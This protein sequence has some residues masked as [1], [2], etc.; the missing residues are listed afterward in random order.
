MNACRLIRWH[1]PVALA[2]LLTGAL[3][4]CGSGE[5]TEA[6][7]AATSASAPTTKSEPAADAG[8]SAPDGSCLG[9]TEDQVSSTLG[10]T[11]KRGEMPAGITGDCIFSQGK[12]VAL[13]VT[14][15]EDG[16]D[17]YEAARKIFGKG[18]PE[19]TGVGDKGYYDPDLH[20]IDAMDGGTRIY[21]VLAEGGSSVK[22]DVQAKLTDL[23]KT[24]A[25][26]D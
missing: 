20:A 16:G 24:V 2:V 9:L 10:L 7:S 12:K 22:G 14:L 6:G 19:V 18:A 4:A 23:A 13:V 17:R 25:E 3:A 15:E 26:N 5:D 1:R 8:G 21:V 11:F